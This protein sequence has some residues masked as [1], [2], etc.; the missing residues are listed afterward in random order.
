MIRRSKSSRTRKRSR[1]RSMRGGSVSLEFKK[2]EVNSTS[3]G[4]A[5]QGAMNKQKADNESVVEM[6]KAMAGGGKGVVVPQMS[7][8]GDAGN[9][10]ITGTIGTT[11][12]GRADGEY[13]N[14]V[15][16]GGKRRRSRKGG[17]NLPRS[18]PCN[19]QL[20]RCLRE[21]ILDESGKQTK[22]CRDKYSNCMDRPIG[23]LRSATA[24]GR[25]KKKSRRRK[26]RK[27]RKSRRSRRRR[28]RRRRSR[29]RR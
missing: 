17:K 2:P 22:A 20:N 25:R 24:G 11:L 14:D 29:R 15:Y 12:Q 13:D 4:D 8:A 28:S 23:M 3:S 7:Q 27:S 26:R 18:N 10:S 16:K 1:R 9:E 19:T 6:N 5:I 21:I